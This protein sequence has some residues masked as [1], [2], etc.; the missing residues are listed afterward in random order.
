[1][2]LT[3]SQFL[4]LFAGA[5]VGALGLSKLAACGEVNDKQPDAPPGT[6]DGPKPDGPL[7]DGPLPDGPPPD[8][9]MGNCMQ[10]GTVVA[11]GTNHGHT[12][13][14]PAADV[15]AGGQRIYQIQ[16]ASLHPHTVTVT[17]AMFAMLQ[18]N[19]PVSV[20]SSLDNNHTH[21]V[22]ITCAA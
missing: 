19:M 15:A 22:T 4:R 13:T 7:P 3:R 21:T 16:G 9:P 12:M 2:D 14:V 11:I 17:A 20:V 6:L 10:N 8:G 18:Q 5:G 1:M